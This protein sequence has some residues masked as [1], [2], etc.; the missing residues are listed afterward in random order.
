MSLRM[1]WIPGIGW[2]GGFL[3]RGRGGMARVRCPSV[4]LL[5]GL[6]PGPVESAAADPPEA[7][8]GAKA[9]APK[10]APGPRTWLDRIVVT[11]TRSEL[12]QFAAPYATGVVDLHGFG[13]RQLHRTV[14]ES[15]RDVPGVMVQKTGHAQG[16]P[17][18]R[19]F[20]GFRTLLM[21]DGI[22]VNNSV[23][24]DGP[25]QY[26]N[27]VDPY[28]IE[29]LEIVKGP[30]SVLY[31][32]DAIG[33][34]VN[35][36]TRSYRPTAAGFSSIR[37]VF[38][39]AST[40]ERSIV[41]RGEVGAGWLGKFTTLIG[42]TWQDYG[43]V[44]GGRFVGPQDRTGYSQCTG[45]VKMVYY[46]NPD[47]TVT[48][49]HYNLY[50][51]DA[52]R[53]HKTVRGIS[54][55]GTTVG[56]E[57]RRVLDQAHQLTYVRYHHK[58][59]GAFV[60]E[61]VLTLSHQHQFEQRERIRSD[62]RRDKQGFDLHTYHFGAQFETPSAIGGWTYGF[63]WYH[64]NV[65][66][67]AHKWNADGSFNSSGIQGPVGDDASYDLLGTYVQNRLPLADRLSLTLGGRHTYARARAGA[68]K[69]P[70]TGGQISIE[71]HWCSLVGSARLSWFPDEAERINVFGGV[72]Q[73]FRAPNLSDLTRLDSARTDEIETPSP[74]LD[75]EQFLTCE[76]GVK[77]NYE[78]VAAQASFFH[79]DINDMIVRTPTGD[80]VDGDREVT[81]QNAGDGS[82]YGV[83]LTGRYRFAPQWTAFGGFTWMYGEVTTFPTSEADK[84][85][86]P[87]DR[88][89]PPTGRL[90]VRWDHPGK[91][92]WVEAACTS[93]GR[94][95]KLSTRDESDTQR[96]PPDG[97]PGYVVFDVR[98]GW[99]ITDD[100]HVWAGLENLTNRDY[101]IHGSGL[102]EPGINF[103]LGLRWRF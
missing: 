70:D 17:Y 101:R 29:R 67:F 63:E 69:D 65:N 71:D 6:C 74:G 68:V 12:A 79:T 58:N 11:A 96:I 72:S 32:S 75:P 47:A 24:R 93:A 57:L 41:T 54:W 89:M 10:Q 39:R 22:R 102:N 82:V 25:N 21:V 73:G 43:D 4:L 86:E 44:D 45:D 13:G 36:I 31:G 84:R 38:V 30:S 98:G 8:A 3:W 61:V 92:L 27:T 90:G 33:G 5:V 103:K 59:I 18:I 66:S 19:G 88:L 28:A 14:P 35:A 15:L 77:A 85:S 91:K 95:D 78:K 9:D 26:W 100:V 50:Q 23:F 40:A 42:G 1:R 97:T 94:A 87:I 62:H 2:L 64:D 20:T 52:W 37:Q 56:G 49:A 51:D 81:K 46:L 80:I 99:K 16:S 76:V 60:D 34:A 55:E 48:V 53:S 83:E 7:P